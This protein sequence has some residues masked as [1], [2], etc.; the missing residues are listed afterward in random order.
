M[1]C[2]RYE[3]KTL[4]KKERTEMI[5]ICQNDKYECAKN[6]KSHKCINSDKGYIYTYKR[7]LQNELEKYRYTKTDSC[8]PTHNIK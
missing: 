3:K 5:G 2:S 8:V 6:T 1:N 7:R 4:I